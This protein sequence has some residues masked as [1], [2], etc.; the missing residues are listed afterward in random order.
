MTVS[1]KGQVVGGGGGVVVILVVGG[2]DVADGA[3]AEAPATSD[4][5]ARARF[6]DSMVQRVSRFARVDR[7]ETHSFLYK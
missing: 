4:D 2:C 1:R 7:V 3:S 6:L 5:D